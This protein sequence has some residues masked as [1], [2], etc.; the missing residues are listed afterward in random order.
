M[1]LA[2][3]LAWSAPAMAA[4]PFGTLSFVE[5]TGTVGPNDDIDIWVRFTLDPSSS[6]LTLVTGDVSGFLAAD[7]PTVGQFFNPDTGRTEEQPFANF[8][9]AS[10]NTYFTCDDTFTNR[11]NGAQPRA[12]TYQ[13]N[14]LDTQERPSA[15]FKSDLVLAPGQSFDYVFVTLK[16]ALGGA[17]AGTYSYFDTGL[18]LEFFGVDA[19]GNSLSTFGVTIGSTCGDGQSIEQ[20]AFT[21]TV[22]AVPEPQ[23]LLLMGVG[24]AVVALRRRQR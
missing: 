13:W 14:L 9:N 22:V 10:L 7:L 19:E 24:L 2:A 4:L 12:Y 3:A 11:C 6:P 1:A 23:T 21:R 8:T 16:P 18:T 20:C 5:P 17:P 15:I